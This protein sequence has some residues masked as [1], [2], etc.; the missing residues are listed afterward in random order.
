MGVFGATVVLGGA[1]LGLWWQA[2]HGVVGALTASTVWAYLLGFTRRHLPLNCAAAGEPVRHALGLGNRLTLLRGLL[3]TVLAGFVWLPSPPG[4]LAYAPGALFTVAALTDL[5]DGYLARTRGE[6]THLGAKLD[7]E[8]D[9]VGLLVAV[10]LAVRLG[11]LPLAFVAIGAIYYV[12]RGAVWGW[13]RMGGRPRPL[14]ASPLRRLVGGFQVGFLC[15]ILW[16][17]FSPPATTLA[18]AVFAAFLA[19]SFGRDALFVTGRLAP[20]A[21]EWERRVL[22]GPAATA[23][24]VAAVLAVG[25]FLVAQPLDAGLLAV[26]LA[27]ALFA[28]C[29]AC[30]LTGR[31][32]ATG[33]LLVACIDLLLVGFR[34]ANAALLVAALLVMLLGTGPRSLWQPSDAVFLRPPGTPYAP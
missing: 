34:P 20:S 2:R 16:P 21:V 1:A 13:K 6:T 33:L 22:F 24:R 19:L 18:G 27:T 5:F 31:L 12:F 10:V 32:G 25:A 23:A 29:V 11:Q 15:V 3:Y 9:S 26:Y 4:L 30:G 17:V 8:V 7:V 28:A 14:P